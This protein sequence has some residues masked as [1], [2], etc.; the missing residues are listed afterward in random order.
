M[1]KLALNSLSTWKKTTP[2]EGQTRSTQANLW[3]AEVCL[4]GSSLSAFRAWLLA[5]TIEVVRFA[6]IRVVG[7]FISSWWHKQANYKNDSDAK[8]SAPSKS[9][10]GKKRLP[11]EADSSSLISWYITFGLYHRLCIL[12][13]TNIYF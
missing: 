9:L 13:L 6:D 3:W 7:L 8:D 11:A 5:F 12:I 1:I 4:W 10:A 2:P